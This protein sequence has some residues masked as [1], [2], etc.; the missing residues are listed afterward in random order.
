MMHRF[1]SLAVAVSVAVPSPARQLLNKQQIVLTGVWEG[2]IGE[3]PVRVCFVEHDGWTV[4]AYYYLSRLRAIPL[5]QPPDQSRTFVEGYDERDAKA[6]HWSIESVQEQEIRGRWTEGGRSLPVRLA[7]ASK[8][9]AGDDSEACGSLAFNRPRLGGVRVVTKGK[10]IKDGLAFTR[11]ALDHRG[12]FDENVS[13]QTFEL[14]GN[15]LA[16]YRINAELRKPLQTDGWFDCVRSAIDMNGSDG[17]S[18][19]TLEPRMITSRWLSV[20]VETGWECGGAHSDDAIYN[21]LFDRKSGREVVLHKW[22]NAEAFKEED[23]LFS[24]LPA[25]RSVVLRGRKL[26]PECS[27]TLWEENSWGIEL[28]RT[29]F[30][31]SPILP[32]VETYCRDDFPVP[33]AKLT[34]FLTPE[35]KKRV[36]ALQA[37]VAAKR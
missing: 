31:F 11:L 20:R 28:T 16:T 2:A 25:F 6:P 3:L 13:A 30:V 35:G 29:G 34:L 21:E 4:G 9:N 7:F 17:D 12:H 26:D 33:F 19:E 1:F 18:I 22:F 36:A 5:H 32:H 23:G 8:S 27:D 15:D 10:A 37:E 24:I 14:A